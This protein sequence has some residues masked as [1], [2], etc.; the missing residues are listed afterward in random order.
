MVGPRPGGLRG[1]TIKRTVTGSVHTT[2]SGQPGGQDGIWDTQG[3]LSTGQSFEFTFTEAGTFPYFCRV[4][5]SI[6]TGT[7]N[8]IEGSAGPTS[9]A[10]AAAPNPEPDGDNDGG[11]YGY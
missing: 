6:M 8:V 4:H 5:G 7:V 9:S 3:F 1:D 11:T 2:T 10:P